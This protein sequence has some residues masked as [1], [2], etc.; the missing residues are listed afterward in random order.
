MIS[1]ES[2]DI[3]PGVQFCRA[4]NHTF[5]HTKFIAC[6]GIKIWVLIP[7]SCKIKIGIAITAFSKREKLQRIRVNLLNASIFQKTPP[8][9]QNMD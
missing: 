8:P 7:Y 4:K 6:I 9:N 5:I 1:W 2:L 3:Q